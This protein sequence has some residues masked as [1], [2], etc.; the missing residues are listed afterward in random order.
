MYVFLCAVAAQS[1]PKIVPLLPRHPR[2]TRVAWIPD[3]AGPRYRQGLDDDLKRYQEQGFEIEHVWLRDKSE[4]ELRSILDRVNLVHVGGGNAFRLLREMRRSG[5]DKLIGD[6]VNQGKPYVGSSAGSVVA[7]PEIAPFS[8]MDTPPEGM[9]HESTAG[10]GLIDFLPVPH[11]S[12]MNSNL[13]QAAERILRQESRLKWP[14]IP[15]RDDQVACVVEG[16]LSVI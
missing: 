2:K 13:A 11:A 3:A 4:A 5:F 12:C 16:K 9:E 8:E 15:L 10:L 14:M 7:G 1:L 6:H